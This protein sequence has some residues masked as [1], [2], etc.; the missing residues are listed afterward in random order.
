MPKKI[1]KDTITIFLLAVMAVILFKNKMA[2]MSLM[3]FDVK[4]VTGWWAGLS[5]TSHTIAW[6]IMGLIVFT[7]FVQVWFKE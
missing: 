6:V 1:K 2:A 4:D 3:A 5:Q 7:I